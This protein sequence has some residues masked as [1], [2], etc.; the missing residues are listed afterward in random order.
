MSSK[1]LRIFIRS[2]ISEIR[3]NPNVKD[4]LVTS[5]GQPESGEH[6]GD[7][8]KK[9]KYDDEGN[10]CDE[11]SMVATSLTPG[12]GYTAPLGAKKKKKQKFGWK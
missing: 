11:M 3:G 6:P 4:Q 2:V 7:E 9:T 5:D 12:G 1:S 10:E 8:D